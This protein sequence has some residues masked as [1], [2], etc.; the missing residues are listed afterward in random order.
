MAAAG[1]ALRIIGRYLQL[2]TKNLE[3]K[4]IIEPLFE[5]YK[6]KGLCY[7]SRH[8]IPIYYCLREEVYDDA[9]TNFDL[10]ISL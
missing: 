2:E 10:V 8:F 7:T 3:R 9:N 1:T 5:R 6:I 4:C